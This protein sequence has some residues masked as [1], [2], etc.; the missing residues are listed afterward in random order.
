LEVAK[1]SKNN[2]FHVNVG[3]MIRINGN[4]GKFEDEPLKDDRE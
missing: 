4:N 3:R 2:I 1:K